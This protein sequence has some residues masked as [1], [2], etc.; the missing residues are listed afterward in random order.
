MS[1]EKPQRHEFWKIIGTKKITDD[2]DARIQVPTFGVWKEVK[3]GELIKKA[4]VDELVKIAAKGYFPPK[5]IQQIGSAIAP[6]MLPG[7]VSLP[8]SAAAKMTTPALA[9]KT[10]PVRRSKVRKKRSTPRDVNQ[11]RLNEGPS[12]R[13]SRRGRRN[14]GGCF[15]EPHDRRSLHRRDG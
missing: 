9:S 2:V 12:R 11:R 14:S 8:G 10:T 15:Y 5:R 6:Q 1:E 4:F 3:A 13:R 7:A